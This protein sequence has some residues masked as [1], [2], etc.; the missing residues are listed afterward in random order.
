MCLSLYI[1][2]V[3]AIVAVATYVAINGAGLVGKEFGRR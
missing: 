2:N 1:A 3:G